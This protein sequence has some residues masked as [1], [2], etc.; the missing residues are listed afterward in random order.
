MLHG[1]DARGKKH[2]F[3]RRKREDLLPSTRLPTI[4]RNTFGR[5][6]CTE[7]TS[8]AIAHDLIREVKERRVEIETSKRGNDAQVQEPKRDGGLVDDNTR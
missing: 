4:G 5:M 6:K 8:I 2:E 7:P 3:E 1:Y